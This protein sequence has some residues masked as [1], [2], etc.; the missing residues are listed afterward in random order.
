M[1]KIQVWVQSTHISSQ[2]VAPKGKI[3]FKYKRSGDEIAYS[4]DLAGKLTFVGA[5]YTLLD[6]LS[7]YPCEVVTITIKRECAGSYTN[8]WVGK[9]TY[10]DCEVDKLACI[11]TVEVKSFDA[12][13]EIKKT[14]ENKY[15]FAINGGI[16]IIY[17]VYGTVGEYNIIDFTQYNIGTTS[18]PYAQYHDPLVD[19]STYCYDGT[20]PTWDK[21]YIGSVA[22]ELVHYWHRIVVNSPCVS[23]SPAPPYS[24]ITWNLVQ[25]NC[26]V[27]STAKYARC[28]N[29]GYTVVSSCPNGRLFNSVVVALLTGYTVKSDFFGINPDATSP[30]NAAYTFATAYLQKIIVHQ[31]SDI[32]RPTSSDRATTSAFEITLKSFLEDLAA[33]F[34]VKWSV[35]GS[36]FR[37]EH[38]SYFTSAAGL[39]LEDVP[40]KMFFTTDK[41]EYVEKETFEY[42]DRLCSNL[43]KPFPIKYDCGE[44]EKKYKLQNFSTDLLFIYGNDN[45]DAVVDAGFV[46]LSTQLVSSKYYVINDNIPL[47][48]PVLHA[49]LFKHARLQPI[50]Y[51]NDSNTPISFSTWKKIRQQPAFT[52]PL[53]CDVDF[54]PAD[55][56]TGADGQA[57]LASGE[58]DILN[59]TLRVELLY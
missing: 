52:V 54:D 35:S 13:S 21:N 36:I 30:S 51:M 2:Q 57:E 47:S 42:M 59:D 18:T 4:K 28:P 1:A 39:D 40:Q 19:V 25:N 14:W 15:N 34:N 38:A 55:S 27:D 10:L 43:F 24:G 49:N 41:V 46:L 16:S 8:F 58:Y 9:F 22:A 23:G 6:T 26:G 17:D 29:S 32:K 48:Y 37:L 44:G 53:C 31:K 33:L 20:Y 7:A 5:N 45:N 12:L 11:L 50:G 56:I 3:L